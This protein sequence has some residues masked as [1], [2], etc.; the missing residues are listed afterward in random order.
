MPAST[1][2]CIKGSRLRVTGSGLSLRMHIRIAV[3]AVIGSSP[4]ML[5]AS[6]FTV[7]AGSRAKRMIRKPMKA[8]QKPITD[9][10]R[11]MV[12]NRRNE[13]APKLCGG[14]AIAA[15]HSTAIIVAPTSPANSA[16]RRVS[17][18]VAVPSGAGAAIVIVPSVKP[19]PLLF[20]HC[21]GYTRGA[22]VK[23]KVG[24]SG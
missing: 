4:R 10:G 18:A 14:T 23:S 16:R 7:T 5:A 11:V 1:R 15:S 2:P 24:L 12:N 6:G 22:A 17:V 13:I 9:Q 19:S 3:D 8:F 20:L 21:S